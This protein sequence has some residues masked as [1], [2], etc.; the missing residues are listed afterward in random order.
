MLNKIAMWSFI[1]LISSE[2][3]LERFGIIS[4]NWHTTF[5]DALLAAAAAG[6]LMAVY[7]LDK[8]AEEIKLLK[9]K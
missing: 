7:M 2:I 5:Q 6:S 8:M 4:G 9:G 1:C 3:V